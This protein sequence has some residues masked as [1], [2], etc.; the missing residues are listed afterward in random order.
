M[1]LFLNIVS[2]KCFFVINLVKFIFCC[3]ELSVQFVFKTEIICYHC[4]KFRVRG[5]SSV[6]LNSISEIGVEG[7]NVASVPGYLDCVT[8]SSFNS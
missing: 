5:L 8:Y 4:N 6:V 7:I 3:F 2:E 1:T